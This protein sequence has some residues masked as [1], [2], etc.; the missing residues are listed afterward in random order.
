VAHGGTVTRISGRGGAAHG[1][2]ATLGSGDLRA[3]RERGRRR[4]GGARQGDDGRGGFGQGLAQTVRW[5]CDGDG[6]GVLASDQTGALR[7]CSDRAGPGS[8]RGGRSGGFMPTR[9][10][11]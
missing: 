2:T 5:C 11:T 8:G 7:R 10:A 9:A 1:G 3:R 6:E 4:G